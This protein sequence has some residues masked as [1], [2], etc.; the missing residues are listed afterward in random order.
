[1]LI[2][3]DPLHRLLAKIFSTAGCSQAESERIGRY[4]VG[5]S[6]A[7]HDSHGV[8]RTQRYIEWLKD[9]K[10]VADQTLS[11]VTENDVLAVV[12]G[13]HGF[14]QTI[15]PQAVQ[16]GIDK[17]AKNGV[18]II[19]LRHS[20]HLGRIGDWPEMA[21]A[22]GQVSVHFVNVAGSQLV[23]PF[24]G[25]DRRMST[26]PVA[27]GLPMPDG[28]PPLILDFATSVVAEGKVL[29]AQNGGKP[30]PAGSL[31]AP[32][33]AL[34][35]DPAVLYGTVE[36]GRSPDP[37]NGPGAIRAMGEHKGSGLALMCEMLAGAL[38]GS[39]CAGPGERR[40][41]NGMLSIYMALDYFDAD[42]RFASEV[43]QYIEFFK[44][45]RPAQ[46]SDEVL[47]P[48]EVERR[49]RE[50]RLAAGIT[51]PDDTWRSIIAAAHSVGLSS[52]DIDAI[53][54]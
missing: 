45:S 1:M 8:I 4:L 31:I 51:L 39:G 3:A 28:Q 54:A 29:V 12:D 7:G 6:L 44:S 18:A 37:R 46:G 15:G 33:G 23:A 11:T 9:G 22:A 10:M 52:A 32:D 17:A 27:I 43:K 2:H 48:G 26:N 16:L 14:G 34:S 47:L 49:N 25:V 13:G 53:I 50:Q 41:A 30:L 19:A 40:I 36:A 35:T 24:G 38:T 21:A 5:A 20:G 42:Q